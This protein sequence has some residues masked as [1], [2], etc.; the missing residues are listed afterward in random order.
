QDAEDGKSARLPS[1]SPVTPLGRSGDVFFYLD[2]IGQLAELKAEKHGRL[3]I[4]GLFGRKISWLHA[5]W[6]RFDK[7][8]NPI[9]W[10]PELAAEALMQAASAEGVWNPEEK[11]RGTGAWLGEDGGLIFHCGDIVWFG[12]KPGSREDGRLERPGRIAGRIYPASPSCA[13]PSA[14]PVDGSP[15]QDLLNLLGNWNWR[16]GDLDARL[17]LGWIGAAIVGGALDWRPALWISGDR[18][19]GKS[20]LHKVIHGVLGSVI[21]ITNS[22]EAGIR[23]RLGMSSLPVAVDELEAEADNR[24]STD[25]VKLARLASSGAMVLR[26][27]SDHKGV[28]FTARSCFL[29]SSILTPPLPPQD[30]SRLAFLELDT[31][32]GTSPPLLDPKQLARI[33]ADLRRL[34]ADRWPLFATRLEAFRMA[35]AQHG[36]HAGRGADQFGTL[37]ACADILLHENEPTT[38]ELL[39]MATAL[40]AAQLAEVGETEADHTK[41]IAHLLS[42]QLDVYHKNHRHT[43]AR[44]VSWAFGGDTEAPSILPSFGLAVIERD[45]LRWL[46]VSNSHQGVAK[47]FEGTHWAGKANTTG[48]WVQAL[49]RVPGAMPFQ[50]RFEGQKARCRILPLEGEY[51]VFD[52][53]A[54]NPYPTLNLTRPSDD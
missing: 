20:T 35:L 50:H 40:G 30:R 26:G 41:C 15:A 36:G 42:A 24:R 51:A 48:V 19:T 43:V 10:R 44:W 22:S 37:L 45:G 29:F 9:G 25:V 1:D 4:Q 17:L 39:E 54:C 49:D 14:G 52:P 8:G 32:S 7:D 38:D 46:A 53:T 6:Q 33:G 34:I 12:P 28:E 27:G 3:S 47:I 21:S 18:A 23:Q 31:L 13:R 2:E 11:V 5:T 16:R